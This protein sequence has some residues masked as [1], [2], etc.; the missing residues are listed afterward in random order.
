ML[1]MDGS[2]LFVRLTWPSQRAIF[3]VAVAIRLFWIW[4]FLGATV[5]LFG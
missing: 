3:A 4:L 1:M 5:G 2:A